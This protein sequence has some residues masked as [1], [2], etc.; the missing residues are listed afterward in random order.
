M[1]WPV[2]RCHQKSGSVIGRAA[3]AKISK[4]KKRISRR[5]SKLRR[6]VLVN[7]KCLQGHAVTRIDTVV[8]HPHDRRKL[9]VAAPLVIT[10]EA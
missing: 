5:R 8:A 2:L 7:G 9:I 3:P 6:E 10:K 4:M 1:Y